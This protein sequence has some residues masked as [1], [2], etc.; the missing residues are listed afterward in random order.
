MVARSKRLP[1]Q[2]VALTPVES[3]RY[4][5]VSFDTLRTAT[6]IL[7]GPP[8]DTPRT[9]ADLAR[10]GADAWP[11]R[12]WRELDLALLDL[13]FNR[14]GVTVVAVRSEGD[15]S[16]VLAVD[17]ML[18]SHEGDGLIREVTLLARRVLKR[19]ECTAKS[20]FALIEP[21]SCFSGSL[22][23]IALACDRVYMRADDEGRTSVQTSA[24]NANKRLSMANGLTRL[25][26]RFLATPARVSEV[27]A[28]GVLGAE[29]ALAL[30]VATF[31]PDDIDWDDEVRVAFEERASLSP[32]AMTGMEASLR[33]GGPETM[34]TKIFARLSAWQNWIFQRPNA[35]GPKGALTLYGHPE[36]PE[37]D[38]VRT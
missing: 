19:L 29:K 34:E 25:E 20:F 21:G 2:A 8:G 18:V 9:P 38:F 31:A 10:A 27:L 24:M 22:L 12:F 6:L 35:V 15:V 36:R 30:G 32:D 26:S 17:E 11:I 5:T 1:G 4:V 28:G 16:R 14:P 33:F 3:S 13:R 37:F 7:R 23:E